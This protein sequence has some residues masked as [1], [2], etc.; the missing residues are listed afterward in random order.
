LAGDSVEISAA[1]FIETPLETPLKPTE[2]TMTTATLTTAPATPDTAPAAPTMTI[3]WLVK[4]TTDWLKLPPLGAGGRFDFLE[5]VLKPIMARHPGAQLRFFD[6]EAFTA[7]CTD[8]LMW[9]VTSQPDYN[10]LVEAFRET[11]FWGAYF[12]VLHIIPTV[13]DGYA[14][15]Y[16]QPRASDAS[17]NGAPHAAGA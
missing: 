16:E 3:F 1:T 6:A 15:H 14:Q 11:L 8:V 17:P 5:T 13:E 2:Q 12:E 9:R 7:V 4:T 10:A